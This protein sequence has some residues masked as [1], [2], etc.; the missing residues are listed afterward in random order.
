MAS[1]MCG[2]GVLGIEINIDPAHLLLL[3]IATIINS[4]FMAVHVG[5]IIEA[6]NTGTHWEPAF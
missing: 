5:G 1:L 6:I 3:I 2:K 4:T